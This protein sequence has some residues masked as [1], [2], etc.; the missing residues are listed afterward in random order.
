MNSDEKEWDVEPVDTFRER[1][2]EIRQ[3]AAEGK[4]LGID[5]DLINRLRSIAGSFEAATATLQSG[6]ALAQIEN[7]ALM[8]E[9]RRVEQTVEKQLQN[10]Y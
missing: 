7:Q 2:D 9:M 1:R 4:A 3:H 6:E 8:P 5:E 10:D